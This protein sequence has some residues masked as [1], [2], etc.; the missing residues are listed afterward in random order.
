VDGIGSVFCEG[1]I[2]EPRQ[3][4]GRAADRRKKERIIELAALV[5]LSRDKT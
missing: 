5:L 1:Q 3:I 4:H 2:R